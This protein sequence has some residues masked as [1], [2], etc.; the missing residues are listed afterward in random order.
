[1]QARRLASDGLAKAHDNA[2][3]IWVD[4]EGKGVEGGNGYGHLIE[5]AD[6]RGI[7]AL[8]FDH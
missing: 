1:V 3:L 6:L 7:V 8:T 4:A 5:C 2:K